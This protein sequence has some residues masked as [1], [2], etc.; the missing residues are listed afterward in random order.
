VRDDRPSETARLIARA[1]VALARDPETARFV[2][3]EAAEACGWFLEALGDRR[4]LDA[5][6]LPLLRLSMRLFERFSIPGISLHYIARKRYIEEAARDALAAG[7]RQVVVVGAGFDTLGLRLHRSHPEVLFLEIDHP[8][9]QAVK[10]Q[11]LESHR[12]SGENLRLVAVDL[13]RR[14][15]A[16]ALLDLPEYRRDAD[17]LLIAEGLTMYLRE[18]DVA[19][20]L[21]FVTAHAGPGSRV[22]FTFL[23]RQPDGRVD[24]ESR[25]PLVRLWLAWVRESFVWG[26]SRGELP[27]FLAPLGLSV[28][29]IATDATLRERYLVP[30]GLGDRPLARG[31]LICLAARRW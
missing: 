28:L 1:T 15:L 24:F 18:E 23:E 4:Q 26:I 27:A 21:G 7:I 30:V 16:E 29:E 20:L 13:S 6:P 2:P 10:R 12:P 14:T 5:L 31:E 17:T 25:N 9:T 19:R 22:V 8:A 3:P 11:A